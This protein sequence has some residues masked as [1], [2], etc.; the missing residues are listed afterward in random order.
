MVSLN[1]PLQLPMA[2]SLV[3]NSIQRKV[4]DMERSFSQILPRI[5]QANMFRVIPILTMIEGALVK[6]K[7]FKSPRYVG[8]PIN[9]LR[10][11]NE[12]EVDEAALLD[13]RASQNKTG[14]DLALISDVV[15]EA[16]MPVAYGGGIESVEQMRVLFACGVEKVV[17]SAA[18]A[19]D[20]VLVKE[21]VDS[22]GSQSVVVCLD[23][24]KNRFA[25][26]YKLRTANGYR[27]IKSV[28]SEIKR[29]SDAGAGEILVS[30][31]RADGTL[32]G[33]DEGLLA[34]AQQPKNIPLVYVGGTSSEQDILRVADSGFSG[35]GVGAL[36][37]FKGPRNAVLI[38]YSNPLTEQEV[39]Y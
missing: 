1:L 33:I 26:G 8:D 6:T 37:V 35:I 18:A 12:K 3:V 23:F 10:I 24:C 16:F 38:S 13:I 30:S 7:A 27:R 5:V 11:F 31:V 21:A 28:G 20:D 15:S 4:I 34:E 29:V 2:Q 25:T 22:F 36:F 39:E 17:I 19:L 32:A 9:A 14:I